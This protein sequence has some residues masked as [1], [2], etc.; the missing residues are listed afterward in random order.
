M[1]TAIALPLIDIPTAL[2]Q[3]HR[4]QELVHRRHG[5]DEV[6]FEWW[7]RPAVLPVRWDG[8]LHI[9]PWGS[10][11]RRSPLPMGGWIA[12]EHV[13]QLSGGRPEEAMI[14]ATMGH[15][16]GMWFVIDSGIRGVVLRGPTG[17]V[18]YLLTQA[19]TNY[20]RNMTQQTERMPVFVGQ[21]I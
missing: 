17:P 2:F 11:D 5:Q 7:R 12:E 21:V 6:R 13:G 8:T 10:K 15:D 20:Y 3:R 18:A 1:C 14:P 9:L 19:S 16:A 4:L